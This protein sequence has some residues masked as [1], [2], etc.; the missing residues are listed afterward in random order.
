M[1]KLEK[2]VNRTKTHVSSVAGNVVNVAR[3]HVRDKIAVNPTKKHA[4][5]M[6][7]DALNPVSNQ[8]MNSTMTTNTTVND[9]MGEFAKTTTDVMMGVASKAAK[10]VI[11]GAREARHAVKDSVGSVAQ[12]T[13]NS[14]ERSVDTV[15]NHAVDAATRLADVMKSHTTNTMN[16]DANHATTVEADAE[17]AARDHISDSIKWAIPTWR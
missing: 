10:H 3:E 1:D 5:I 16:A 17:D 13:T 14:T 6:T 7:M 4:G 11:S 15:K 2:H 8:A 9:N 12:A